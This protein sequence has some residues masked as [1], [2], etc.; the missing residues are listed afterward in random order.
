MSALPR[1]GTRGLGRPLSAGAMRV[2]SPAH[3]TIAVFSVPAI[4]QTPRP[5]SFRQLARAQLRREMAIV[6]CGQGREGGGLQVPLEISPGARDVL[7]VVWLAVAFEQTQP[8]PQEAGIALSTEVGIGRS[9]GRAVERPL[10]RC[11]LGAIA[12]VELAFKRAGHAGAGILEQGDEI[13][14]KMLRQRIL[15]VEDADPGHA[16]TLRQ[17]H[18]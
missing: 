13:E 8:Q 15:E 2:P 10:A 6:P 7:N 4:P 18:Q 14:G 16:L 17:P 12:A 3:R 11:D 5:V 9:K 1:S